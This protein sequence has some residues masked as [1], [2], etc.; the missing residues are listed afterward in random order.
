MF[1]L[2]RGAGCANCAVLTGNIAT[3]AYVT[4]NLRSF[5]L[6]QQRWAVAVAPRALRVD[7]TPL[8]RGEAG[9]GALIG[10]IVT[11]IAGM[12]RLAVWVLCPPRAWIT[13]GL[14]RIDRVTRVAFVARR[15]A[16]VGSILPLWAAE[17]VRLLA[18]QP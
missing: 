12:A 1:H 10:L 9:R 5:L 4:F 6:H 2:T 13:P 15:L 11:L 7:K 14:M 17:E 16:L 18:K 3:Q 8:G